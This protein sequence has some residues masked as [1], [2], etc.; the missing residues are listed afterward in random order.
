MVRCNGDAESS[1][2]PPG[3]EA[4]RE[5]KA[6]REV[7]AEATEAEETEPSWINWAIIVVMG[8]GAIVIAW[9]MIAQ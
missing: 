6:S 4:R 7:Q 9:R 3:S 1:G 8:V 5:G 2:I